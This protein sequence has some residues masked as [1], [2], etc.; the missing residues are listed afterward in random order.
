[1]L[2]ITND[3]EMLIKTTTRD[4]C[5]PIRMATIKKTQKTTSAGEDVEKLEFQECKMVQLLWRTV[6]RCLKKLKIELPHDSG[7]WS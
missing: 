3:Q 4:H 2:N 6:W 7:F 5:T 1:M